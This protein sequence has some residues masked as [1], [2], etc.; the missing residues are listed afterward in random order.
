MV[1][2]GFKVTMA[3]FKGKVLESLSNV[4]E[5][6]KEIKLKNSEQH[7]DFYIRLRKLETRPAFSV[8]P[9]GWILSLL[10]IRR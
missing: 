1:N 9:M 7:R 10:R 2:N 6:I 4:E 3:E 8:S 5:D